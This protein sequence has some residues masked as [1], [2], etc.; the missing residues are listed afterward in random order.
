[1]IILS[2]DVLFILPFTNSFISLW[3]VQNYLRL[4]NDLILKKTKTS[5]FLLKEYINIIQICSKMINV[6]SIRRFYLKHNPRK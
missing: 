2:H 6:W 1:M 5:K 4:K 3:F